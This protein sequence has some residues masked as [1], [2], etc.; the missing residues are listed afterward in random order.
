MLIGRMS[1]GDAADEVYLRNA[2]PSPTATATPKQI[3]LARRDRPALQHVARATLPPVAANNV[4]PTGRPTHSS[5]VLID[6]SGSGDGSQVT[7]ID[8]TG[9][10]ADQATTLEAQVVQLVNAQRQ[11]HGCVPLRVDPRLVTSAREHSY[12]MAATD[13]FGHGGP[14]GSD[15]WKRMAAAGYPYGKAGAEN[16]A[17]G[18]ATAEEAV[19][20]WM[21][22][23][24]FRANILNCGLVATGVGVSLAPGGPW[25]TQDFGYA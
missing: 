19:R 24:S 2:K 6:G 9:H 12:E 18:Y 1:T 22:I 10:G 16:I 23:S 14:S 4:V 11:A 21:A 15:P 25:W 17:R 3:L 13:T 7:T 5:E 8:G 20:K